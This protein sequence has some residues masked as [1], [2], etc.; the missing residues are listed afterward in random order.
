MDYTIGGSAQIDN[1][2]LFNYYHDLSCM[3]STSSKYLFHRGAVIEVDAPK[4]VAVAVS[5]GFAK[6]MLYAGRL[7]RYSPMTLIRIVQ[8]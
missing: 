7:P 1:L 5:L 2:D 8:C 4:R 3:R 6:L